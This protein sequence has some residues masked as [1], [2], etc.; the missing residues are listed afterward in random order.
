MARDKSLFFFLDTKARP[1]L[2]NI[3]KT[4]ALPLR[5]HVEHHAAL[6]FVISFQMSGSW[7][8]DLRCC[9]WASPLFNV[10]KSLYSFH[11]NPPCGL[12][13]LASIFFQNVWEPPL[14]LA[15]ESHHALYWLISQAMKPAGSCECLDRN[16][17]ERTR[18]T[19]MGTFTEKYLWPDWCNDYKATEEACRWIVYLQKRGPMSDVS[20]IYLLI[21][22]FT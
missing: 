13:S 16:T 3:P 11:S 17:P 5:P 1:F 2:L 4:R 18:S 15:A 19:N 14:R 10:P 12:K 8:C 9:K 20:I 7:W 22:V 6:Y 21:A